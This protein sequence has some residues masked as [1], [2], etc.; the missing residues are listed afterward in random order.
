[1]ATEQTKNKQCDPLVILYLHGFLSSPASVKA[2]QT[3][4][5]CVE[6]NIELHTPE[7]H[8]EPAA[9]IQQV[10]HFAASNLVA[11]GFFSPIVFS[12]IRKMIFGQEL[13]KKDFLK[14]MFI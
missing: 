7:L 6:H 12:W 8:F 10:S 9:A 4:Q 2:Q 5:Y 14:E 13:W 3:S 11:S 1:M